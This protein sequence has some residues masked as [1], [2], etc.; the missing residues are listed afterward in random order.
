[1]LEAKI[2]AKNYLNK[3]KNINIRLSEADIL[4]LK[5]KSTESNI[6][7]QTLVSSLIHQYAT[8]KIQLHI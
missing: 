7:Y 6:P 2:M 8:D 4:M 5:R 1:M 3:T